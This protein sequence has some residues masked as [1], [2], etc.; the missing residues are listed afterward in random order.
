MTGLE[1]GEYT[2]SLSSDEEMIDLE[3]S[4]I[5]KDNNWGFQNIDTTA[6][7]QFINVTDSDDNISRQFGGA[8]GGALLTSGSFT[9]MAASGGF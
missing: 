4:V 8:F 9:M 2:L 1:Y 3:Y 6:V 5:Y 7:P